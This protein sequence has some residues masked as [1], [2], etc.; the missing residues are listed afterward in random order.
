MKR[1]NFIL[2]L[3]TLIGTVVGV[4][5]GLVN[6]QILQGRKYRKLSERNYIR[7]RYLYPPR[8]DIYDRNG[9]K[10]AYDVPQ[11]VLI[12]DA[13][14][15]DKDEVEKV[16]A[17]LKELYNIELQKEKLNLE[18]F[19]PILLKSGLTE[20]EISIYHR[21][22]LE[23]PGVSV[24]VVPK[25]IYAHEEYCCHV[26]G[27]VGY[28]SKEELEKLKEEVGP[29]S[30]IGR[31]GIEKSFDGVLRGKLG[32]EQVVVNALGKVVKVLERK[33]PKR[34]N[35]VVLT[36][37]IRFQKIV[38]D[39]FRESGYPAGAVVLLNAQTGEVLALASFPGF[40]PN[41]IYEEWQNL[42]KNQL[43][44]LFNRA[45]KGLYPPASVFKVPMAFALLSEK[46]ITPSTTVFCRGYL[47]LGDRR[48]SCWLKSGHGA[49]NLVRSLSESCDVYYYTVGLKLGP[50][51]INHY[52][53][54]FSYGEEIPFELPI[55]KGFIPT[56]AWK[57]KKFGEPWY[58]G[59]TIN[60]SI[61]Q[62]F[63]LSN[64]MEQTLMMMGIANDGVIY[65]PT[66]LKAIL[67]DKGNVVWKNERKVWKVV[68]G[69]LE[70][71]AL[72]KMGL[73]EAVRR[74]TARR[75]Y[76]GIVDIAGK[77]GTAEAFFKS[78][79]IP[80]SKLP[81]K[82]RD[83]AWFVGFAPY[84]DPKFVIGVF[85]EHGG[86]GG[87]AAAPIARRILERI[88]IERLHKEI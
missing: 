49:V 20:K 22:S 29:N 84:R 38:E 50:T 85:V 48:F 79:G 88:Y 87:E 7:K 12:L 47:E 30:L 6:L 57:R 82:Y 40:N 3:F 66:L 74:G 27:Y 37:D 2:L 4:L 25:R 8:G 44:P 52:A 41:K 46:I 75:A 19:E 55:R 21:H 58:D 70:H 51:K 17:K 59:D 9:T 62:G 16:L 60:M 54:Q 10:L 28:P 65:K 68:H 26:L 23:L 11:Y 24:E 56:P 36:I 86:S 31:Y 81:R 32:E 15:L 1:R 5:T 18:R 14:R 76:S 73:R 63:I 53:R 33:E 35:S 39:V 78:R 42:V 34:G 72:V 43:N 83:H 69:D 45:T 61:G 67:D 64:L 80:K 13:S 77:T 71:F